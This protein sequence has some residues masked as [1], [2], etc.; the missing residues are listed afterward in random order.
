LPEK[1]KLTDDF[2]MVPFSI[3]DSRSGEWMSR[4]RQWLSLGFNSQESREDVELIA[5]SG[6]STQIYELRNQ[7]REILKREPSWDEIIAKAKEKGM[8][9]FEGA[10]IF[11]PVLCELM[12]K[13]FCV[14]EGKVLDPF[15]G[16]SVR[17]IGA[18]MLDFDYHCIDLRGDQVKAN[19]RQ[20]Q[21]M[22]VEAAW[23][24]G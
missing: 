21:E 3:L 2:L 24:G 13:W 1:A 19:V 20:A 15:A 5:K 23:Y 14:P 4:K 16:G 10:S 8:H 17:G 9:V 6:Q 7:M 18:G 12:Y 22:N 11:D